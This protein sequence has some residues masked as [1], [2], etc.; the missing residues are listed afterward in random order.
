MI[1]GGDECHEFSPNGQ[2][3]A[4]ILA[5]L[6]EK[7]FRNALPTLENA[8]IFSLGAKESSS[9]AADEFSLCLFGASIFVYC[10][11]YFV[12]NWKR[13][14]FTE[15]L[16]RILLFLTFCLSAVGLVTVFS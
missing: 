6:L 14:F 4:T 16:I 1:V 9:N 5:F 10:V 7:A 15:G 3:L 8:V 13:K 12:W 11:P 2:H